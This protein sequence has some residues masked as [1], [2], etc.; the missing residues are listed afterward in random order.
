VTKAS[1]TIENN[2]GKH[3]ALS[4]DLPILITGAKY[5]HLFCNVHYALR[6]ML[7]NGVQDIE[8]INSHIS[9]G[10]G[11]SDQSIV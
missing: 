6:V 11:K 5:Q 7:S 1:E 8:G 2:R 4:F 3:E 10:V 9:F